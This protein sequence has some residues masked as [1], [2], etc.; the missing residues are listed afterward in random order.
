MSLPFL[1]CVFGGGGGMFILAMTCMYAGFIAQHPNL[2]TV[3]KCL[4]GF[5]FPQAEEQV[6][7]QAKAS[8]GQKEQSFSKSSRGP[9]VQQR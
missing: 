7:R 8:I 5:S 4:V 6:P 3:E 2:M 9:G 1:H